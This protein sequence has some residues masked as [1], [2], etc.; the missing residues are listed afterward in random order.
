[1]GPSVK[2]IS[3][4]KGLISKKN[5][6]QFFFWKNYYTRGGVRGGFGKRPYVFQFFLNPSLTS[7]FYH[8][9]LNNFSH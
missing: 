4:N 2:F 3:P 6:G 5:G 1:M 9:K 8:Y 7:F